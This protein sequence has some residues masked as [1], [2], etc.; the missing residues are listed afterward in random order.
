MS[1]N[2]TVVDHLGVPLTIT[3]EDLAIG[4]GFIDSDGDTNIKVDND[5]AICWIGNQWV[6]HRVD[7]DT[8]IIPI[9]VTYTFDRLITERAVEG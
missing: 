5:I 9:K 7:N 2:F 3:I 6:R 8:L 4:D 1:N